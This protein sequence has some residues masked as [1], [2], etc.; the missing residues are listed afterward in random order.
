M[1]KK[2]FRFLCVSLDCNILFY[3]MHKD[4][5]KVFLEL[6]FISQSKEYD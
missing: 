6:N 4:Y 3:K 1:K 2:T 5:S